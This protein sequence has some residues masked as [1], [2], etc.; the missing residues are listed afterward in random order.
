MNID[1]FYVA[2]IVNWTW[3]VGAFLWF[4]QD[5]RA[6]PEAHAAMEHAGEIRGG[7]QE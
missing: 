7:L 5:T 4:S 3:S 6:L 1:I 2:I